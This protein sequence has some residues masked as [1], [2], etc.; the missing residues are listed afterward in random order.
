MRHKF[1][2]YIPSEIEEGVLYI[3]IEYD[4]AKHKCPCGCGAEIVTTL[5]PA[6]WKLIYDGETVS[7]SPSIGNWNH[8]CK[9][10]YFIKN[11]KVIWASEFTDLQIEKVVKRDKIELDNHINETFSSNKTGIINWVKR[12]LKMNIK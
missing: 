9:S 5:S 3:S 2:E 11:D 6:R 12:I 10:H 4:V 8:K 1:V 7:L